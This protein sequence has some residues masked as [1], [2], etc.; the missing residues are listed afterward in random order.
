MPHRQPVQLT[1]ALLIWATLTPTVAIV[2]TPQVLAHHGWSEY[3]NQ[4]TLNL[5]GIIR[6]IGYDSPHVVIEL[7]TDDSKL[8]RAVL[9]PPSRMQ[10]RGLAEN[11]LKVG[12]TVQLVGYPHRSDSGEMRAEQITVGQKTIELR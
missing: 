4:Q 1:T 5:T 12:E 9:A 6:T 8:W 7:E 2:S 3:D 11:E 10:N